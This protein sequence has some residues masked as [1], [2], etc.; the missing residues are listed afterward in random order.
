MSLF[1]KAINLE[2]NHLIFEGSYC[3]DDTK[4]PFWEHGTNTD[5]RMDL[6]DETG[7]ITAN[8]SHNLH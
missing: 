3:L 8:S 2:M 1:S 4:R 7:K 5:L 6:H